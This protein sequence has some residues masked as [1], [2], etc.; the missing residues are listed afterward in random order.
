MELGQGRQIVPS[1]ITPSSI[2]S[3][4]RI[5]RQQVHIITSTLLCSTKYRITVLSGHGSDTD[6]CG[7]GWR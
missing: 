1:S 2:N 6:V 3:D 5:R 4:D 7:G